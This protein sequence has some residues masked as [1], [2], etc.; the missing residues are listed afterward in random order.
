MV[1]QVTGLSSCCHAA[2]AAHFWGHMSMQ[3]QDQLLEQEEILQCAK[4]IKDM[5]ENLLKN[6][7]KTHVA[8]LLVCY[9]A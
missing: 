8:F 3:V 4:F 7:K 5:A 9:L 1:L 6:H 2:H